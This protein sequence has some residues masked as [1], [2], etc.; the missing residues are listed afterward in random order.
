VVGASL[1]LAVGMTLE[2]ALRADRDTRTPMLI[3]AVVTAVK[4]AGNAVLIFGA[5]PFP[6]LELVGAGL[7]TLLSQGI[8]LLLFLTVLVRSPAAR[9]S[10]CARATSRRRARSCATSCG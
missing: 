1:P 4:I 3:A 7:A 10:R 6:R 8:G 5:G 9:R 2:F